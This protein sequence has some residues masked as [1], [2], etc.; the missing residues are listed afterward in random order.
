[1]LALAVIALFATSSI[2]RSAPSTAPSTQP[3]AKL[4]SLIAQL[5]DD[6]PDIRDAAKQN[7]MGLAPA[8]LSVLRATAMSL[9]PLGLAQISS[10]R[11]AVE[12]VYLK[13]DPHPPDVRAGFL[14]LGW[15][16]YQIDPRGI[17]VKERMPGFCAYRM[18]RSEDIITKLLDFPN[19]SLSDQPGLSRFTTVVQNAGPGNPLRLQVI[20]GGKSIEITVILDARPPEMDPELPGFDLRRVLENRQAKAEDYWKENFSVLDSNPSIST[21]Q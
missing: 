16:P 9:R 21:S 15:D 10:L 17:Y 6:D 19:V 18:L 3:D 8:D 2:A 5:A 4:K 20:R 14:G 12:H 1:M 13:P 7:L 11:D